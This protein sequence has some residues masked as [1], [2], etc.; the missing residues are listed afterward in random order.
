VLAAD[1]LGERW[2]FAHRRP[3]GQVWRQLRRLP[4]APASPAWRD[5]CRQ[6]HQALNRSAGEVVFETGLQ[7]FVDRQPR[8]RGLRDDIAWFLARSRRE[9]FAAS[10][11]EPG[12]AQALR[13]LCR[14]LRDAERADA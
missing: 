11:Q 6:V 1:R 14:R 8:F 7:R 9:F 12:D 10:A 13:E 4:D 5:A 2:L 3:F